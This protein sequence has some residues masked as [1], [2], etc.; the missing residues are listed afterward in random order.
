MTAAVVCQSSISPP[1]TSHAPV[2]SDQPWTNKKAAVDIPALRP[3]LSNSPV[4]PLR[5]GATL[6]IGGPFCKTIPW[7]SSSTRRVSSRR[8][9]RLQRVRFINPE[10]HPQIS[11]CASDIHVWIARSPLRL[12]PSPL[13]HH[14]WACPCTREDTAPGAMLAPFPP[15]SAARG[16]QAWVQGGQCKRSPRP[17]QRGQ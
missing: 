5:C 1:L 4:L 2:C 13:P 3:S 9:R 7:H 12:E 16:G 10:L 8:R 11:N 15:H 14:L 6:G 17:A